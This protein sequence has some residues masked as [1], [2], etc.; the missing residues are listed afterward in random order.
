MAQ[1]SFFYLE[2]WKLEIE[3]EVY[4]HDMSWISGSDEAYC[5]GYSLGK[6][7]SGA[8]DFFF[9]L[10]SELYLPTA[11][12]VLKIQPNNEKA[13][14][15][16]AKILQEKHQLD[17]AI[18]FHSK[19]GLVWNSTS[20]G[21]LRRI[22]RLYPANKQCHT[23]LAKLTNKVCVRSLYP[24]VNIIS[25][26]TEYHIIWLG[27]IGYSYF[28]LKM[29][30]WKQADQLSRTCPGRCWALTTPPLNQNLAS[31]PSIQNHLKIPVNSCVIIVGIWK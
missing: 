8:E 22:N 28:Y 16:K 6:H 24:I 3:L 10:C 14:F 15:R 7:T 11:F 17:E 18:G 4:L 29:L 12:Q 31:S 25:K 19:L 30:R 2:I 27:N 5:L 9:N 26:L 21:I 13:L 23:E 20:L 1:V